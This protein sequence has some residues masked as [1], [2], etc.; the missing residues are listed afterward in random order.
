[1][2]EVTR[3]RRAD[4]ALH[5]LCPLLSSSSSYAQPRPTRYGR[6]HGHCALAC[7]S[8]ALEQLA[9]YVYRSSYGQL[10]ARRTPPC[11]R[12]SSGSFC[13]LR[14]RRSLDTP[15]RSVRLQWPGI[16]D[17]LSAHHPPHHVL[18]QLSHFYG[19]SITARMRASNYM[20]IV[21]AVF[22]PEAFGRPV[23]LGPEATPPPSASLRMWTTETLY[24][25]HFSNTHD[26]L[27]ILAK[28]C[29]KFA[30]YTNTPS[31]LHRTCLCYLDP[32]R[33]STSPAQGH[34]HGLHL[35]PQQTLPQHHVVI[36][37]HKPEHKPVGHRHRGP[38]EEAP[39]RARRRRDRT[40]VPR[41]P[42][43]HLRLRRLRSARAP[44][45]LP[46]PLARAQQRRRRLLRGRRLGVVL[47]GLRLGLLRRLLRL[48][49]R[50]V[51]L[52][53]VRLRR[54]R[55]RRM[56]FRRVLLTRRRARGRTLS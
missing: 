40:D 9:A 17:A 33:P 7:A 1:M 15:G 28:C 53:R 56:R 44:R 16:C 8:I 51:R 55:L 39:Q 6:F 18:H 45:P 38:D 37:N 32:T 34:L 27:H 14:D 21:L 43:P 31:S 12:L 47:V 49:L 41:P 20:I 3:V 2:Q 42:A 30:I 26:R 46:Q 24:D 13:N 19:D 35:R 36:I 48:R 23:D 11:G 52:R 5:A 50:R 10:P 22:A 4:D 25:L 54:V 29:F